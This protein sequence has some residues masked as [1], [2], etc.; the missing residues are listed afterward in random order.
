MGRAPV[1]SSLSKSTNNFSISR[2]FSSSDISGNDGFSR[3]AMP[4]IGLM[5]VPSAVVVGAFDELPSPVGAAKIPLW[6]RNPAT[7]PYPTNAQSVVAVGKRCQVEKK[8]KS[9]VVITNRWSPRWQKTIHRPSP[10]IENDRHLR[11]SEDTFPAGRALPRGRKYD[12]D[13][14]GRTTVSP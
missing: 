6:K 8:K 9:F 3:S 4:V 12:P 13:R 1:F 10:S 11:V 2:S 14:Q 7:L 5:G